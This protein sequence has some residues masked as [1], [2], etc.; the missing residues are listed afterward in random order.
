MKKLFPVIIILIIFLLGCTKES[1][2][3]NK[4]EPGVVDYITGAEQIKA[5]ERTKSKI[6]DINKTLK[7]QRQGIE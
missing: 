7:E 2:T 1:P 5:Y 3:T 6:E 4:P